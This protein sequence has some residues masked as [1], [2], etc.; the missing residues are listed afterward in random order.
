MFSNSGWNLGALL[1]AVGIGPL[2]GADALKDRGNTAAAAVLA[3]YMARTGEAVWTTESVELDASLLNLART[4]RLKAIRRLVPG[5]QAKYEVLQ[6][7][8]DRTVKKQVIARYLK[9]LQRAAEMPPDSVALTP[10]NYKFSYKGMAIDANTATYVFQISPRKKR[11]GLIKG[12][13]Q[14]DGDT[15]APLRYSGHLVKRPSMFIKK[16]ELTRENTLR[17]GMIESQRTYVTVETR[18]IGRAELVLEE[19]PLNGAEGA[20][21]TIAVNGGTQQ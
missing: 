19:R 9:A 15:A 5:H 11:E 10:A 1:L 8:G 3:R 17:D 7:T 18:L 6:L 4:G 21:L 20:Q 16:V 14:L 12:E 2:H 13:L